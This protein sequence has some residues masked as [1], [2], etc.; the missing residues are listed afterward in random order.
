M[1][2]QSHTFIIVSSYFYNLNLRSTD[3]DINF[4]RQ[5]DFP[6]YIEPTSINLLQ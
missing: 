3:L 1:V 6:L 2:L 5:L 4:G